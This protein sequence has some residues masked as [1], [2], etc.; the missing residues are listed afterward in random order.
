MKC[1]SDDSLLGGSCAMKDVDNANLVLH[2]LHLT[3][4]TLLFSASVNL[5]K[6]CDDSNL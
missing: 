1:P 4:V 5:S 3:A 2:F 6:S